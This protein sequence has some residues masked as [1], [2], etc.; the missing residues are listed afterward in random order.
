MIPPLSF[1]GSNSRLSNLSLNL[2]V[3]TVIVVVAITAVILGLH[4]STSAF[5]KSGTLR[6]PPGQPRRFFGLNKTAPGLLPWKVFTALNKKYGPIASF[7]QGNTLVVVLQTVKAATDLLEK[8]GS[9]YSS[10]PRNIMAAELMSGGMRGLSMTYGQRWRNWRSLM[11]AGLGIEASNGYKALQSLESKILLN[12]LLNETDPKKYPA[13]I[14]RYITSVVFFIG[15]GRRVG[16]LDDPVVVANMKTEEGKSKYRTPGKYIVE[17]WPILLKL[18]RFM[19]WFRYGPE[20]QRKK[21]E[22][23]YVSIMDSVRQQMSLG[24]AHPSIATRGVLRQADFGLSDL[25][26]A[27]ALSAPF[28][29][30]VGTTFATLD[31][32]FL[33]ML[34]YPQVM[35][36]AQ[37][38]IDAVVG[39]HRLPDFEDGESLPYIRA[40]VKET[41]R[42]RPIIATGISHGVITDDEYEGWHIPKGSAIYPNVY[43]M[44]KDEEMFPS[45]DEFMPERYLE[46]KAKDSNSNRPPPHSSFFFGFGRRIC[47]GMHVAQNSLFILIARLLWALDVV[48]PKDPG[49]NPVL[50]PKATEDFSGG[51]ILRPEKFIY[52]LQMRRGEE[53]ISLIKEEAR[54][55]AEEATAWM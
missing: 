36:K 45:A 41:L 34:H 35:N 39:P 9:I 33:A 17:S 6:R 46:S 43:A 44:S 13:H 21:D 11:H 53:G 30:G 26:T 52:L 10:R 40:L 5:N 2:N 15:Y 49:G 22:K 24:H 1:I 31:I 20:A 55:A 29:A 23:L 48:P 37:E 8:R 42:W 38:E 3:A 4:G 7:Y 28:S 18:P 19:Q 54:R 51:L 12:D 32:F 47:P 50:P 25:E 14:R 27:F 16:T